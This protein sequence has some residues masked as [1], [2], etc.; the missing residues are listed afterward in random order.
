MVFAVNINNV[1][2][3]LLICYNDGSKNNWTYKIFLAWYL[4]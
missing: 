3:Q 1:D 2:K 4:L